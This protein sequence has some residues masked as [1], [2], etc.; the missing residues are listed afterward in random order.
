MC[1]KYISDISQTSI[2]YGTIHG[3]ASGSYVN[4]TKV[5]DS[6]LNYVVSCKVNNE[7]STEMEEMI[8]Q[9]IESVPKDQFTAL[10]GD[11]FISGKPHSSLLEPPSNAKQIS[12]KAANSMPSS[13]FK[14]MTSPN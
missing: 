6:Q 11:C 8:F 3:N 1:H 9:P 5:L 12:L 7:R 14:F 10:Y 4:E 2:K 13:Q